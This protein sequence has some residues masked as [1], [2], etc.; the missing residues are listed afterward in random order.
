M[1]SNANQQGKPVST[2]VI[3]VLSG[4]VVTVG[5]LIIKGVATVVN[6]TVALLLG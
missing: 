4:V 2:T 3:Y 1:T 6:M 5:M